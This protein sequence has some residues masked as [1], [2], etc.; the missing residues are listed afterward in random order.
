MKFDI[1]KHDE[2]MREIMSP[3]KPVSPLG[4]KLRE[5]IKKRKPKLPRI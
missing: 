3:I 4:D 5:V 2:R 1:K